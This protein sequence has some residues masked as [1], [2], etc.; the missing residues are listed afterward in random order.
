MVYVHGCGQSCY[1]SDPDSY[2]D[3]PS[4]YAKICGGTLKR[5]VSERVEVFT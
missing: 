5:I 2:D 3:G 1:G 4:S